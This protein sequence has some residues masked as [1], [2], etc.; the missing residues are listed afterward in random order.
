MQSVKEEIKKTMC[1]G[2]K[3]PEVFNGLITPRC[4]VLLHGPP[5]C[6]KTL[7]AKNIAKDLGMSLVSVKGPELLNMYIGESEKNIREVFRRARSERPCVIFLDEFDALAPNRQQSNDGGGVMDRVVSQFINELDTVNNGLQVHERV[8]VLAA[9][10]RPDMIDPSL[11][12][13]GR[14][15]T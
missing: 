11:L 15:A 4:G 12:R 10:N 6:G 13:S 8:Y 14:L 7:L 3:Y 1:L 5:G 9:T 2:R